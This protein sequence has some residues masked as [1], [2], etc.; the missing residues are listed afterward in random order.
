MRTKFLM[1]LAACAVGLSLTTG[2]ALWSSSTTQATSA[3]AEKRPASQL[4]LTHVHL[5]SS[6]VGYFQR[7]GVVE[8]NTRIDLTFPVH[9]LNDLI[10][11]MVF[12]DLDGGRISV[13]GYDSTDPSDKTLRSFALNLAGKPSYA[14]ILQ[15][16]RGEKVEV[17]LRST[18]LTGTI[19]GVEKQKQAQ[20]KD[21]VEVD[22]LNLWCADGMRS[23]KLPDA[24]RVRFLNPAVEREVK[25]AL[26]LLARTHDNQ[27]KTVTLSFE[28]AGKRRVRVGYVIESPLWKTSYRLVLGRDGKP[29]LQGW[30][31]VDNPTG[32]DWSNV[33][34]ALVAGRPL[35]FQLDLSTP[36][37]VPRP[38][39]ELELFA[40]LRPPTYHGE[41]DWMAAQ[42]ESLAKRV[43][44]DVKLPMPL[45]P[46][47]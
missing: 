26:E 34:L 4:P 13:V 5:F 35:S 40:G 15:Q 7:E 16:A 1:A 19:L 43:T 46:D 41:M 36:I 32:E 11:S 31:V 3:A 38:R 25:Q 12:Q 22:V 44:G 14:Q 9:N 17:G 10:K 18:T 42:R 37:Y 29:S 24:Q 2:L 23:V 33:R 28:G 47:T 27:M 8:G 6:G 39:V 30:A 45:R 20:G 21:L